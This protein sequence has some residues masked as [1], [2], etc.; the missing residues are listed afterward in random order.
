MSPVADMSPAYGVHIRTSSD[1]IPNSVKHQAKIHQVSSLTSNFVRP[2]PKLPHASDK[3]LC[4]LPRQP[5][6]LCSITQHSILPHTSGQTPSSLSCQDKRCPL[7]DLSPQDKLP[8]PSAVKPKRVL[9]Q[10]SGKS[11]SYLRCHT[12]RCQPLLLHP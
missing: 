10:P 2:H 9:P 3:T 6:L 11:P 12:T 8:H 1:V 4:S 5:K 7:S